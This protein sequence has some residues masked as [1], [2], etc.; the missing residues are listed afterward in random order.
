MVL[1][2]WDFGKGVAELWNFFCLVRT[3]LLCETLKV[4]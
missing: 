3:V 4:R 1:D 2:G